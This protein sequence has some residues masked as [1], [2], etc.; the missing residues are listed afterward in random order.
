MESVGG[1]AAE[2]GE[3]TVRAIW[4]LEAAVALSGA[5]QAP[6][7][8]PWDSVKTR[9]LIQWVW[10]R[11]EILHFYQLPVMP[12]LLANR[13]LLGQQGH[14]GKRMGLQWADQ[15]WRA[16]GAACCLGGTWPGSLSSRNHSLPIW[17]APSGTPPLGVTEKPRVIVLCK[18]PGKV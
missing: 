18:L 13:S 4:G 9:I 15:G 17:K 1:K 8:V 3:E 6:A 10:G 11:A 12:M 5:P 2:V 7:G 14:S 16:R